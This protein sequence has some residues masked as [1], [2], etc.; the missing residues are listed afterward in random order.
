MGPSSVLQLEDEMLV[1][2][3]ST[4]VKPSVEDSEAMVF[5]SDNVSVLG[6]SDRL[7]KAELVASPLH[8]PRFEGAVK[9]GDVESGPK[10]R[11]KRKVLSGKES[12]VVKRTT[13]SK[14]KSEEQSSAVLTLLSSMAASI[15][16]LARSINIVKT[17]DSRDAAALPAVPTAS[18]P[19][20]PTGRAG[21]SGQSILSTFSGLSE[22]A[23]QMSLSSSKPSIPT[24]FD[25]YGG[26]AWSGAPSGGVGQ[27]LPRFPR[28][29]KPQASA[30]LS[31]PAHE[32]EDRALFGRD[33]QQD[34][35]Y[36]EDDSRS[37]EV[38]YQELLKIMAK[39]L[40]RMELFHQDIQQ[41]TAA[42][43]I[44]NP[45][46]SVAPNVSMAFDDDT[47]EILAQAMLKPKVSQKGSLA[48]S[49]FKVPKDDFE[50]LLKAPTVDPP[51]LK[52]IAASGVPGPTR[53]QA[54]KWLRGLE[55][56]FDSI[57]ST[58]RLSYHQVTMTTF[59]HS[60][61]ESAGD[62]IMLNVARHLMAANLESLQAAATGA[63]SIISVMRAIC[64]SLLPRSTSAEVR[65]AMASM[66][67]EGNLLFGVRLED[68]LSDVVSAQ[69]T[70]NRFTQS[71]GAAK[72]KGTKG[73][74][75]FR[76]GTQ[77]VS[78]LEAVPQPKQPANYPSA[79]GRGG[80]F[81]GRR[82]MRRGATS[83]GRGRGA[84]QAKQ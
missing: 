56:V 78:P 67:Y 28:R 37:E 41:L 60:Q 73:K 61:A 7:H 4:P 14:A 33:L 76:H 59:I 57:L 49:K 54:E 36:T 79:R 12:L 81:R 71:F 9:G 83:R 75:N 52:M 65:E 84:A 32:V 21:A 48:S 63:A 69:Q 35:M 51:I 55:S 47:V 53:G 6:T 16:D 8:D 11:K 2:V 29:D 80:G 43:K 38:S 45:H 5:D 39:H 74:S 62:I 3:S 46:K 31:A 10:P 50:V 72:S 66:P 58:F 25:G 27:S 42:D 20:L 82:P 17:Q 15:G 34:V 40:N 30:T 22:P 26:M 44:A 70:F 64:I 24:G 68:L 23:L 77:Q 1:D 19:A 13:I 18:A